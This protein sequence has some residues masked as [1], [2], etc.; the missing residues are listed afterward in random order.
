MLKLMDKK[1]FTILRSIFPEDSITGE[2]SNKAAHLIFHFNCGIQHFFCASQIIEV[3]LI[4]YKKNT[5]SK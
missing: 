1:I 2:D 5:L 4:D 3:G